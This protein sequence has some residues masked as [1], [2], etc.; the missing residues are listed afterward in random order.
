MKKSIFL[1]SALTLL[2]G[3]I[4]ASCSED[5]QDNMA[6][7]QVSNPN[8]K[9]MPG[10]DTDWPWYLDNTMSECDTTRSANCGYVEITADRYVALNTVIDRGGVV[11][12][13]E[14]ITIN[15]KD[16]LDIIQSHHIDQLAKKELHLKVIRDNP[17]KLIICFLNDKNEIV[18]AYSISK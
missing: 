15:K 6:T 13:E 16:L 9:A 18:V 14:Y 4:V 10:S 7:S 5:E 1:I 8:Q 12:L 11:A 2:T 3:A 17:A